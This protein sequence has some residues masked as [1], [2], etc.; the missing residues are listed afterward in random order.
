MTLF[1]EILKYDF[2]SFLRKVFVTLN[3][4][5]KFEPNWHLELLAEIIMEI[6]AGS[7]NKRLIVNLPPRSLKSIC[8]SVAWP[9]WLLGHDKSK[10]IIVASYAQSLANK[11]SHDC[12]L[13]MSS[14]WYQNLFPETKLLKGQNKINKFMTSG[15]GF[16]IAT[17]VGGMMTGEGADLIVVDDPQNA[18]QAMS[19]NMRTRC[20]NWFRQTLM[21]RLND[22]QNG[23]IALVMQRMHA[24]DLSGVLLS[25]DSNNW[26]NI[27]IPMIAENDL[28]YDIG[29][30][31]HNFKEG[32]YMHNA[33]DNQTVVEKLKYELGSY[34]FASQ[35]QQNPIQ[36]GGGIIKKSW[37]KRYNDS[38]KSNTKW[39]MV[40]QSWDC[41]IKAGENHDYSVCTTWGL[42]Q[43]RL[44]LLH[45]FREQ[46]EYPYLYKA[47]MSMSQRYKPNSVLIEDKAAG[48]Q[49]LQDLTRRANQAASVETEHIANSNLDILDRCD[50]NSIPAVAVVPKYDKVTRLM[51]VSPMF[52]NEMVLLPEY[53][54]WLPEFEQELLS[55][56][57]DRHDDQVDSL[58]QMLWWWQNKNNPQQKQKT[59]KKIAISANNDD[60]RNWN[61]GKI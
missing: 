36:A 3:G 8:F 22:K 35:Y 18:V 56:P 24:E 10:K 60:S 42:Y 14:E 4:D 31:K 13:V 55:F 19:K 34:A 20:A 61:L 43:N 48:Q 44:H 39:E 59:N 23:T 1:N 30:F 58:T 9:A 52:E 45:V 32:E 15:N 53:A 40:Y 54:D 6:K 5:Q 27:K 12:R 33:R 16:R 38:I 57:I 50:Y 28:L 21:S 51:L 26:E 11:H 47:I 29:T 46:L 2:L 25:D 17:S 37:I 41:A 7:Y 49:L